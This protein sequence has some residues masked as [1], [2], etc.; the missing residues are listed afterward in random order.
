MRRSTSAAVWRCVPALLV[1][2]VVLAGCVCRRC[3]EGQAFLPAFAEEDAHPLR[4]GPIAHFEKHCARCHGSGGAFYGDNFAK[5]MTDAQLHGMVQQMTEGPGWVPLAGRNLES[6]VAY[7]RSLALG[8]PFLAWLGAS[9]GVLQGEVTPGSRV[10]VRFHEERFPATVQGYEWYATVP[11]TLAI[12]GGVR[13]VAQ[14]DGALTDIELG[15]TAFSHRKPLR[16]PVHA[17]R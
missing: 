9:G 12:S 2:A 8:E 3:V 6:L 15:Q 17:D 14:R 5:E 7:H 11:A 4:R 1:L 13:V 16:R 10:E